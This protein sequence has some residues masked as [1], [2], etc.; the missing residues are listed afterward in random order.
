MNISGS[1]DYLFKEPQANPAGPSDTKIMFDA[2]ASV[3]KRVKYGFELGLG[4]GTDA[5]LFGL[6]FGFDDIWNS[7]TKVKFTYKTVGVNF[8]ENSGQLDD[9]I[10]AGVDNFG[11]LIR[12]TTT[13]GVVDLGLEV[14]QVLT[15]TI[16]LVIKGDMRLASDNSYDANHTE[17]GLTLQTGIVYDIA[18]NTILE[19]FY[20]VEAIPSATDKTTDLL[21]MALSFE[22]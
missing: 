20:R 2:E 22:F 12:S 19:G 4:Q 16:N 8:L 15:E 14:T 7:G 10:F 21:Q 6:G 3:G 5:M 1:I 13:E 18:P 9:E 11:R 17:C